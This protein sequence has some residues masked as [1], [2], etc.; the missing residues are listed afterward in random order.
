LVAALGMASPVRLLSGRLLSG[1]QIRI[2]QNRKLVYNETISPKKRSQAGFLV[3]PDE[4]SDIRG[5]HGD[6]TGN[7]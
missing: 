7:A 3:A 6:P 4:R 1:S 2:T 5:S